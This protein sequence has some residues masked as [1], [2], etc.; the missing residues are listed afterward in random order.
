M[1]NNAYTSYIYIFVSYLIYLQTSVEA[2]LHRTYPSSAVPVLT[3]YS[4]ASDAFGNP[5]NEKDEDTLQSVSVH[6]C[7]SIYVLQYISKHG[8]A[9]LYNTLLL[10]LV[11]IL[12]FC[13]CVVLL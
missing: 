3:L 10:L 8:Y 7:Y 5:V 2:S 9:Q 11:I 13:S 4:T 1:S 6:M 12:T